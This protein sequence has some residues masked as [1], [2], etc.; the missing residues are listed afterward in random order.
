MKY[1]NTGFSIL[2]IFFCFTSFAIADDMDSQQGYTNH[3]SAESMILDGLIYRPLSLAGTLVGTGIYLATLPFSLMGGNAD[4]AGH[5]LV[6]EPAEM[7]F[8]RCLGCL[9]QNQADH[10]PQY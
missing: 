1:R 10:Y 4:Q 5:T 8:K 9:P 3:P 7:T 2:L 6:I